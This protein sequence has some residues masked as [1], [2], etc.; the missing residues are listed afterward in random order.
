M[1]ASSYQGMFE[2]QKKF[3]P[4]SEKILKYMEREISD[5]DEADNWKL[6]VEGE[7]KE[8]KEDKEEGLY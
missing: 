6:D 2:W 4:L 5:L 3:A 8:D 7:D 1:L